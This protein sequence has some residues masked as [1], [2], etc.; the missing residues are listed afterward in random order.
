MQ[1]LME[2]LKRVEFH[3]AQA[4][5][6]LAQLKTLNHESVFKDLESKINSLKAVRET[7]NE[8]KGKVLSA[9]V[10]ASVRAG[11]NEYSLKNGFRVEVRASLNGVNTGI[12]VKEPTPQWSG[13]CS[14]FARSSSFPFYE[15]CEQI[16]EAVSK[17][18]V[19]ETANQAAEIPQ[20][21]A[22]KKRSKELVR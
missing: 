22:L 4:E 14:P 7:L 21:D 10:I 2:L 18:L 13:A 19:E 11:E 8:E 12:A 6:G 1:E 15:L 17:F 20:L 5:S 9:L 16:I 3:V